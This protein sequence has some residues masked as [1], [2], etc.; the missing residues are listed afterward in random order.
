M[1]ARF[2]KRTVLA[3]FA[4]SMLVAPGAFAETVKIGMIT[5]LSGGGSG[6]GIAVRDGFKLA[7][8]QEGG[9]LGGQPVRSAS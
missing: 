9:K 5:T 3:L 8:D 7:I 2:L 1:K 6:L 4:V